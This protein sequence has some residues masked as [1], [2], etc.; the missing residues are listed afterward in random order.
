MNK[1]GLSR[2]IDSGTKLAIRQRCGF[3]C[4]FCGLGIIQYHHFMPEF[5]DAIIHDPSGI[6]LLCPCCHTKAGARIISRDQVIKANNN[7]WCLRNGYTREAF[8]LGNTSVPVRLGASL[9]NAQSILMYD[10]KVLLG[11]EPAEEVG[12]PIRLTACLTDINGD[13]LFSV[14]NNEWQ[15]RSDQ[16]DVNVVAQSLTIRAASGNILMRMCLG[17]SESL[18]VDRLRMTYRGFSIEADNNA[19]QVKNPIGGTFR[20][21]GENRADIGVWMKSTGTALIAAN[22]TGGAAICLGP[23]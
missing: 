18:K 12:S 2:A 20:H 11:F 22:R 14:T 15:A 13:E 4:I 8:Y 1:H 23:G 21:S 3:G 7:P 17:A 6:T 5:K 9:I 10:D 16:Y 19:F